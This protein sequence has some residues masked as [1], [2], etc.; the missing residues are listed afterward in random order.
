MISPAVASSLPRDRNLP[1]ALRIS[2]RARRSF[3]LSCPDRGFAGGDRAR[4]HETRVAARL[5]LHVISVQTL[6]CPDIF[7]GLRRH[8]PCEGSHHAAPRIANRLPIRVR[9]STTIAVRIVHH[10][11]SDLRCPLLHGFNRSRGGVGD[12]RQ[13]VREV[14]QSVGE[15]REIANV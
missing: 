9:L 13:A 8:S 7:R 1:A 14:R 11:P 3:F 12:V 5:G 2:L 4:R 10:H 15:L 6:E